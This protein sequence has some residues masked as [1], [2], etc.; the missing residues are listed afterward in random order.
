MGG[1]GGPKSKAS[2]IRWKRKG[3]IMCNCG[4]LR[5]RYLETGSFLRPGKRHL[6]GS[7]DRAKW[8][9]KRKFSRG[10]SKIAPSWNYNFWFPATVNPVALRSRICKKSNHA[11]VM[12]P[13]HKS[14]LSGRDPA[15][16]LTIGFRNE[17]TFR[18]AGLPSR[19]KYKEGRGN[20][21]RDFSAGVAVIRIRH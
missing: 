18:L 11:P 12:S 14:G 3:S 19:G 15:I 7:R 16:N 13:G 2:G 6:R 9:G 5:E 8:R 21:P 17:K 4:L 20:G 1:G 10:R